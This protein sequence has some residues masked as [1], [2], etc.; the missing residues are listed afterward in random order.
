[1]SVRTLLKNKTEQIWS[2]EPDTSVYEV[3]RLMADRD[4]GAVLVLQD[5]VLQGIFSERDYARK[6]ILQGKMAREL[7]VRD[8][9]TTDLITI[10]PQHTIPECMTL[11][12]KHHI[13]HLPVISKDDVVGLISIR[14]VMR[15]IVGDQEEAIKRL[16]S[17]AMGGESDLI[18]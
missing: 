18:P 3:I 7:E 14:D 12:I 6:V 2:V 1:M 5:S 11:M 15:S 10:T 4:I 16:E 9:M 8:V 13:R 17:F